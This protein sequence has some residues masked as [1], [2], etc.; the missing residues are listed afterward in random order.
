MGSWPT[1]FLSRRLVKGLYKA[2]V[3]AS[4][5]INGFSCQIFVI[6]FES[7][8]HYAPGWAT[9]LIVYCG[10]ANCIFVFDLIYISLHFASV[11]NLPP[12]RT[13]GNLNIGA[14][15]VSASNSS[16]NG[17]SG[18]GSAVG[19]GAA[20]SH[21]PGG[22]VLGAV[23]GPVSA[24]SPTSSPAPSSSSGVNRGVAG[25]KPEHPSVCI[26][27]IP[28]FLSLT[29]SSP[30]SLENVS[31]VQRQRTA[32]FHTLVILDL[33]FALRKVAVKVE[34]IQVNSASFFLG[35]RFKKLVKTHRQSFQM[36]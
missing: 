35:G 17:P 10:R 4:L 24:L 6:N 16:T 28:A 8:T 32:E 15:T 27:K 33:S 23:G 18:N 21:S 36:F 13:A 20:N 1:V 11:W 14:R 22:S 5:I 19:N 2:I 26:R 9:K 12:C 3:I 30:M 25:Q 31:Q 7:N 29:F 34:S